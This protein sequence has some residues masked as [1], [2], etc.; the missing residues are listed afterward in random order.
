MKQKIVHRFQF[1]VSVREDSDPGGLWRCRSR[2][3]VHLQSAVII[4]AASTCV[5]LPKFFPQTY[6]LQESLWKYTR[7]VVPE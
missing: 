4:A 3:P 7:P 5:A 2:P 6:Q 1:G